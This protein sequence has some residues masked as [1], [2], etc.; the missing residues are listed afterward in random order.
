M[1]KAS[2][3]CEALFGVYET[4]SST[5]GRTCL[6]KRRVRGRKTQIEDPLFGINWQESDVLFENND[7]NQSLTSLQ[8]KVGTK[9]PPQATYCAT[10]PRHQQSSREEK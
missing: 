7:K 4:E 1:L 10:P 5:W 3:Y 8:E 9:I 2:F 6:L